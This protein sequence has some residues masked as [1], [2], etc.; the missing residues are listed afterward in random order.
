MER[1]RVGLGRLSRFYQEVTGM[2][3]RIEWD[4]V[5]IAASAFAMFVLAMCAESLIDMALKAVGL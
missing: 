1:R 2:V 3:S 4:E 5:A